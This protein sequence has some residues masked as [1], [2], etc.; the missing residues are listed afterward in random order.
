V[1]TRPAAQAA[2]LA[3]LALVLVLRTAIP[4]GYMIAPSSGGLAFT[5]C[6][7]SVPA[8]SPHHQGH[9][10]PA[11]PKPPCAYAALAAPALPPGPPLVLAPPPP[12]EASPAGGAG[13]AAIAPEP[14]SPPPPSTGPPLP[15]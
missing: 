12:P 8:P 1:R 5:L 11:K 6:E 7:A 13:T 2:I 14:A 15:V 4:A 10:T 3:L 9:E